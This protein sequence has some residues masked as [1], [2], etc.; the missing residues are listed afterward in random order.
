VPYTNETVVAPL[1]ALTEALS[2]ALQPV[3]EVGLVA[4]MV[5]GVTGGSSDLNEEAGVV[6]EPLS[7][8]AVARMK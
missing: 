2:R 6:K 1:L 8:L 3:T 7:L 5:G 4:T